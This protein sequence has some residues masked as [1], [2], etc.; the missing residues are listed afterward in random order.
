MSVPS[1]IRPA[2]RG[3]TLVELLVVIGI[4]ALLIAILL[5]SLQRA[6]QSANSV[7]CQSNQ[8][9]IVL[10]TIMYADANDQTFPTGSTLNAAGTGD[11]ADFWYDHIL[12]YVG[13]KNELPAATGFDPEAYGD[14]FTCPDATIE[15]GYMHYGVHPRL[16]PPQRPDGDGSGNPDTGKAF[17]PYKMQ[18]VRNASDIFLI[19]DARQFDAPT[20]DNGRVHG[21]APWYMGN[22]GYYGIFNHKFER[23]VDANTNIDPDAGDPVTIA[24]I[25]NRDL[26]AAANEWTNGDLRFRHLDNTSI[27]VGYLDGHVSVSKIGTGSDTWLIGASGGN[28]EGF[29]GGEITWRNVMLNQ[30]WDD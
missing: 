14:A 1:R 17:K 23:S 18:Q 4:I 19:G 28:P 12:E 16:M 9:Q 2:T 7:A 29:D 22:F 11:W 20:V 30:R 26:S 25:G 8:R 13:L 3:F 21:N 10:A 6:R 15:A 27:N 5:P 24:A